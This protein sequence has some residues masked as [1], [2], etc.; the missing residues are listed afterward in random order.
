MNYSVSGSG[1][2]N[3]VQIYIINPGKAVSDFALRV[4]N[5]PRGTMKGFFK[6]SL[7]NVSRGTL[8]SLDK[9]LLNRIIAT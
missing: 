9:Y 5:V 6:E 1:V 7:K 4:K 8:K 2:S 3:K